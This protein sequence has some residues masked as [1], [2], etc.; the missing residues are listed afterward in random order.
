M[1]VVRVK[2]L[3]VS[4]LI[5]LFAITNKA[6]YSWYVM[7]T[8]LIFGHSFTCRLQRNLTGSWTNLGFDRSDFN[9]NFAGRGGLTL[10]RLLLPAVTDTIGHLR[11]SIVLIQIGENEIDN[12]ACE[13]I[14]SKLARNI[15]S[16]AQWL[17]EG[18]SVRQVAIYCSYFSGDGRATLRWIC[19]TPVSTA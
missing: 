12:P 15:V 10:P 2:C 18:F 9:F 4:L 1:S 13:R 19:S 11:P 16:F 17:I 8:I 6:Y 3:N 5:N 7:D 14:S